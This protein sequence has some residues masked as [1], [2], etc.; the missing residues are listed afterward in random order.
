[1]S[2]SSDK[3]QEGSNKAEHTAS[4]EEKQQETDQLPQRHRPKLPDLRL[5]LGILSTYVAFVIALATVG[6]LAFYSHHDTIREVALFVSIASLI[7]MPAGILIWYVRAVSKPNLSNR[8]AQ[9]V[10][11]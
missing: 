8:L 9:S 3:D 11:R 2:G 1:M 7:M 4:A 5:L 6:V 10:R